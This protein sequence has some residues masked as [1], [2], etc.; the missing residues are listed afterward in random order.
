MS[1][2]AQVQVSPLTIVGDP[3]A[4]ACE[5]EFCE[6]PVHREQGI[7]NRRVDDDAV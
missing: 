2:Q 1:E 4:E 5:G 7:V 3:H 6:L